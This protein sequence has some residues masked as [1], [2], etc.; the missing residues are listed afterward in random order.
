MPVFSAPGKTTSLTLG[1]VLA[2][3]VPAVLVAVLT[4]LRS[5]IRRLS[6][7]AAS[8]CF[9]RQPFDNGYSTI[10]SADRRTNRP[11]PSFVFALT[12]PKAFNQL[13]LL[14]STRPQATGGRIAWLSVEAI[15]VFNCGGSQLTR[16]ARS[17]QWEPDEYSRDNA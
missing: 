11:Q 5:N 6:I 1:S 4:S 3:R 17:P 9:E 12:L 13:R 10:L 8:Q 15:G 2:L 14:L 7:H 16:F